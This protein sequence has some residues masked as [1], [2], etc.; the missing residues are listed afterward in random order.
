[1]VHANSATGAQLFQGH[2]EQ[3]KSL[4]LSSKRLWINVDKPENLIVKL[5]GKRKT[6]PTGKPMVLLVTPKGVFRQST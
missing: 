5:N 3:G 6:I 1:M 2:L 4:P